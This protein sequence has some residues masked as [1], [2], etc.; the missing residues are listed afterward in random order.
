MTKSHFSALLNKHSNLEH[1]I[2]AESQRPQP[3]M[4][5]IARL[6]KQKLQLKDTLVVRF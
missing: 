4:Q 1:Q 2:S 6:K 5:R 3:D